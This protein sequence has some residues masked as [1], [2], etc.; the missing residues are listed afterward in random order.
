PI[1]PMLIVLPL[2][3]LAMAVV[4]DIIYLVGGDETFAN[5]AFWDITAGII[6]GLAAAVF[7]F[8]DWLAIPKDTRARRIGLIHGTGNFVIVLLFIASWLLRVSDHAYAPNL[9]PF[10]LGLVGVGMA[11]GTAWLGGE[12]VYRMRVGVDD[13]ANLDAPSSLTTTTSTSTRRPGAGVT[14]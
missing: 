10:L 9:L 1:H 5:V 12:L 3:L 4:F 2:G 14:R 6:G 13:G 7:G 8:I 11:L